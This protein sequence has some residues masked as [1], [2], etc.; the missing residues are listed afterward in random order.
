MALLITFHAVVIKAWIR[1][2]TLFS[3]LYFGGTDA[4]IAVLSQKLFNS[5]EGLGLLVIMLVLGYAT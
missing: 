2:V 3:A 4:S 1:L 5:G